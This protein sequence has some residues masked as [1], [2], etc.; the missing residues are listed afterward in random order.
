MNKKT[1]YFFQNN[2]LVTA[3]D[4][5]HD[6]RVFRAAD[7]PLAEY[8]NHE[9]TADLL[10][11]DGGGSPLIT[12]RAGIKEQHAFSVYGHAPHRSG[13]LGFNGELIELT[14]RL[15]LLGSGYHRPYST[16]LLRFFTSD[17]QSPFSKGGINSY[18]YCEG[19]PV[20]YSDPSGHNRFHKLSGITVNITKVGKPKIDPRFLKGAAEFEAFLNSPDGIKY[21][22]ENLQ[23]PQKAFPPEKLLI[24]NNINTLHMFADH[25]KYQ[26]KDRALFKAEHLL[27]AN[28]KY[29]ERQELKLAH[30]RALPESVAHK[31]EHIAHYKNKS[32]TVKHEN[33]MLQ[34][35]VAILRK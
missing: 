2:K 7:M 24:S 16:R 31:E 34:H 14:A 27:D 26:K 1:Q 5:G 8:T 28:K 4:S 18:A 20:N 6:R 10:A 13:L 11:T 3:K 35:V 22:S 19:D 32:N 9:G 17:N 21:L 33:I 12:Q 25:L 30:A 29:L 15:Y 23:T